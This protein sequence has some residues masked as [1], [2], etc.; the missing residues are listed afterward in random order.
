MMS[1]TSLLA[2]ARDFWIPR[3][4][5][6]AM[7]VVV[8]D[9]SLIGSHYTSALF[10]NICSCSRLCFAGFLRPGACPM[11]PLYYEDSCLLLLLRHVRQIAPRDTWTNSSSVLLMIDW[12]PMGSDYGGCALVYLR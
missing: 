4:K 11:S 10:D 6:E 5:M 7:C 2:A 8:C 1:P 3:W 12:S 9:D